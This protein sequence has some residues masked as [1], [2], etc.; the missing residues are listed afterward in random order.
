MTPEQK[1]AATVG[2]LGLATFATL[3]VAGYPAY[4]V[5]TGVLI[6]ALADALSNE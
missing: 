3:A 5:L 1:E 4:G 6:V 2:A